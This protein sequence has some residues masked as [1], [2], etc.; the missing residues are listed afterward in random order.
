TCI[1]G[2]QRVAPYPQKSLT[3]V[4][5]IGNLTVWDVWGPARIRRIH[6]EFY[7]TQFTD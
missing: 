7:F 6:G 2:K 5:R 1:E 4:A 3:E